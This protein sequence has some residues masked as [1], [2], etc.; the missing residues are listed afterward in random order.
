LHDHA[1]LLGL[2]LQSAQL[3][4]GR[5]GRLDVESDME[6][7]KSDWHI[8]RNSQRP[9]EVQISFYRDLDALGPDSHRRS[10]HL[11]RNLRASG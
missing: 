7:L 6:S 11:A 2:F 9:S 3:L 8:L 5:L 4:W 10:H 1:V